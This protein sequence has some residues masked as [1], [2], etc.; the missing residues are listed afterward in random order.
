MNCE[1]IQPDLVVYHFGVI[2]DGPRREVEEHLV[3]CPDCLRS[4]L[5]LKRDIE[6][7]GS[8]P[9][10]SPA[11]LGRLRVSAS[12]ELDLLEPRFWSWWERPF[13]FGFAGVVVLVAMGA[14]TALARWPG[15]AP[16]GFDALPVTSSPAT[17]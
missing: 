14:V 9:R 8:A 13:A 10:P 6:T 11:V 4:F 12:R 3:C 16:R 2:E 7:A 15:N 17:R 5:A 1:R